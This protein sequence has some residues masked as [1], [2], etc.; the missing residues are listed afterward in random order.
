MPALRAR[1]ASDG[2]E[3]FRQKDR[4]RAA[5]V[6]GLLLL[7]VVLVF[8]QTLRHEFVNYDDNLYVTEQPQILHGLSAEGMRWAFVSRHANNWH[9]LTWLSHML[10]CEI[11]GRRAGGHHATN[12]LLHGAAVSALLFVLWRMT[13]NFW[14]SALAAA[15][16]AVHPLRAESVA[17]VSERK[18]VLSGLLFMLTLAA[19]AGYVRRPFSW[20]RYLLVSLLFALGLMA[21]PMLVTLPFVLLL[22]DFWPLRR[23]TRSAVVRLVVEKIPLFLLVAVSCIVTPMAQGSA[24][25]SLERLSPSERI[26]NALI[27]Y[28]AYLGNFFRPSKLAVLYPFPETSPPLWKIAGACALLAAVSAAA[29]AWRRRFPYLLV[30]WF[31]YVGMLVPV[32][33]LVQIGEQTMADRYTY[34]PQIGLCIAVAWAA[35]GAAALRPSMRRLCAAGSSL[36]LVLLMCGAWQQTSYWRTSESLWNR[37]LACTTGNY[38]A[39]NNL[40]NE[41]YRWGRHDEAMEHFQQALAINPN[42][43]QAHNNLGNALHL[44]GRTD[45]ALPHY[46][47]AIELKPNYAKARCNLGVTLADLGQTE[48]AVAEYEEALRI[49]PNSAESHYNM[50]VALTRLKKIDDAIAHYRRAI[51]LKD[52]YVEAYNNLGSLLAA[53]GR[54]QEGIGFLLIA[55]ELNPAH[56]S[57]HAN[58]GL[59]L[60]RLGQIDPA[61][62]C[63]RRAMEL[64]PNDPKLKKHLAEALARRGESAAGDS[65]RGDA[66]TQ[67]NLGMALAEQGKYAEAVAHWREAMRQQP[68]QIAVV[69]RLAW[70]LATCPEASVR[71]SAEAV[72]LAE[73]ANALSGGKEPAIFAVMAAAYAEAG[74]FPNAVQA[75][76]KAIALAA[77]ANDAAMKQAFQKQQ[78]FYRAGRPYREGRATDAR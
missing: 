19:Y 44:R 64:N 3:D 65:S 47:R 21:K 22:L 66:E 28:A 73:R 46:H 53:T 33:G 14:P 55:T 4:R 29:L 6:C 70:L 61:V 18:D 23:V 43:A 26:A 48:A 67:F 10:D 1:N 72:E 13:G 41:L 59:A 8:G 40:G 62:A 51:E 52:D 49:E 71:D 74:R 38:V 57:A 69:S 9:P 75:I 56:A 31:W 77:A 42:Y 11:Y 30:G 32:I 58:L 37:T 78:Q 63:F 12:V 24:V 35:A 20:A 2:N 5:A 45:E 50:A 54:N 76:E 17:W 39:H 36:W 27:A 7:A 25:V 68:N 34:L 16:F 15:V 60:V